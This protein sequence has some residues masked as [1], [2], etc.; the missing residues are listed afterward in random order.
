ML[1]DIDKEFAKELANNAIKVSNNFGRPQRALFITQLMVE[2]AR[3]L[4]EVNRL[5]TITGEPLLPV[6]RNKR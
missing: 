3:L 5:R 6:Y 2:N 1:P 4:Q